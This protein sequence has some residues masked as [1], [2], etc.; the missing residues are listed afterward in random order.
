ME[1]L[2]RGWKSW[3]GSP[4]LS[5]GARAANWERAKRTSLLMADDST[6]KRFWTIGNQVIY[7]FENEDL[8]KGPRETRRRAV[9]CGLSD[10]DFVERLK[11]LSDSI[12]H[13][14]DTR[15]RL[16]ECPETEEAWT[17]M[18]VAEDCMMYAIPNFW[19]R[20]DVPDHIRYVDK[21]LP[22]LIPK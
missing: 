10:P 13:Y 11:E 1:R 5:E 4:Y 7:L 18:V 3:P 16:G 15:R 19:P 14:H 2:A 21:P 8:T 9:E 22:I 6:S 20:F 17:R 12:K